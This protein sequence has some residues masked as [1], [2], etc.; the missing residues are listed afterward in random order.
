MG[1]LTLG[2]TNR[3]CIF[4]RK[5]R[6]HD[7]D[8]GWSWIFCLLCMGNDNKNHRP[9]DKRYEKNNHT[10]DR[11]TSPIRSRYDTITREAEYSFRNKR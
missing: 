1:R 11:P 2:E 7:C 8:G 4:D 3:H 6:I 10:L 5:V 9:C